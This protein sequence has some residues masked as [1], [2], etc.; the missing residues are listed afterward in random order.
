MSRKKADEGYRS[1]ADRVN[2]SRAGRRKK[3]QRREALLVAVVLVFVLVVAV[4]SISAFMKVAFIQVENVNGRYTDDEIIAASGLKNGDSLMRIGKKTVNDKICRALPYVGEAKVKISIPDT[5]LI[6]VSYTEAT[7]CIHTVNGY[8]LLDNTC[9]VLQTNVTVPPEN[10]AELLGT[11]LTGASPGEKAVFDDPDMYR[12]ITELASALEKNGVTDVTGLNFTDLSNVVVEIN[13]NIDVKLGSVSKAAGKLKFG[14]EVIDRTLAQNRTAGGKLVIDLTVEDSAYVRSQ[15]SIEA[16][17]ESR[18]NAENGIDTTAAPPPDE[19]EYDDG[20]DGDE[21][22]EDADDEDEAQND[23]EDEDYGDDVEDEDRGY[24]DE[25]E[26]DE[27]DE[28]GEVV[29]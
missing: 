9:K 5:V 16:A 8:V 18:Y 24:D 26:D 1:K 3:K 23:N 14:K 6:S 28:D 22:D 11:S 10:A 19:G 29:G 4:L 15:D 20:D 2:S 17:S 27:E 12:Y 7:M 25:D 21:N 13:F